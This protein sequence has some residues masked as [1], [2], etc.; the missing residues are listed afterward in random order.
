MRV[1]AFIGRLAAGEVGVSMM[2]RVR[3]A[4]D[5]KAREELGWRPAYRT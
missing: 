1:P 4:A 2:T 3:G 5:A